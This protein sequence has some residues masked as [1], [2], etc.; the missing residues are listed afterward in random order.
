VQIV[1]GVGVN[2][3]MLNLNPFYKY[4]FVYATRASE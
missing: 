2:T 4:L 1:G 3:V